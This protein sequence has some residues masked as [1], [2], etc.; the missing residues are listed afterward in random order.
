LFHICSP[1][2]HSLPGPLPPGT[3]AAWSWN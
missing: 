3:A 1:F 2:C